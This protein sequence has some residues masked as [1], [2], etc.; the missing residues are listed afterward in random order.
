MHQHVREGSDA[1]SK[2]KINNLE[3]GEYGSNPPFEKNATN[4]PAGTIQV[5]KNEFSKA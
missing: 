2:T 4:F 1:H 5:F 3:T